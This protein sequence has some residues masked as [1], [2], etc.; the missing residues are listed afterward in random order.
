MGL[1]LPAELIEVLGLLGFTWPEADEERLF[2]LGQSWMN[3]AGMIG[4]HVSAA[5][6]AAAGAWQGNRGEAITAFQTAWAAADGP[7][8]QLADAQTGAQ[9]MGAGLMVMAGV[10]LALKI[11]VIVQLTIL[12]IEIA[13]AIATAVATFGASLLEIP[14]FKIATQ[15]ILDQLLSMAIDAVLN[16]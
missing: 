16:G 3:A 7:T 6:A 1:Q 15:L 2:E 11:N 13:Q 8:A 14:F 5:D 9:I 12:A 10:V 4:G